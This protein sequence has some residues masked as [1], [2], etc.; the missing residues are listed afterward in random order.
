MNC[1]HKWKDETYFKPVFS[2]K[3]YLTQRCTKCNMVNTVRIG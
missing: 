1:E 2:V 3:E